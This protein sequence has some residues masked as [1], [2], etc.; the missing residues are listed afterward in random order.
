[1][2]ALQRSGA[3]NQA[4]ARALTAVRGGTLARG[5]GRNPTATK[6]RN[7]PR[8]TNRG[9]Q[10]AKTTPQKPAGGNP[11]NTKTEIP[12][13]ALPETPEVPVPLTEEQ[14][15]TSTAVREARDAFAAVSRYEER[16]SA[17]VDGIDGTAPAMAAASLKADDE[18]I[19]KRSIAVENAMHAA[20]HAAAS[21]DREGAVD[22]AR[23]GRDRA[24]LAETALTRMEQTVAGQPWAAA[25]EPGSFQ[26]I[27]A[28]KQK[29]VAATREATAAQ[30]AARDTGVIREDLLRSLVNGLKKEVVDGGWRARER[31]VKRLA[32]EA[33]ALKKLVETFVAVDTRLRAGGRDQRVMQELWAKH[34]PMTITLGDTK[35]DTATK[36]QAVD[37]FTAVL[38]ERDA[39]RAAAD[40]EAERLREE[41]ARP[42]AERAA[43]FRAEREEQNRLDAIGALTIDRKPIPIEYRS[44][45][46][47]REKTSVDLVITAHGAKAT[48]SPVETRTRGGLPVWDADH[49]DVKAH[50]PMRSRGDNYREF[51]LD[52]FHRVNKWG[53]RRLVYDTEYKRWYYSRTHYGDNGSPAFVLLLDSVPSTGAPSGS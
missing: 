33:K 31:A 47:A 16:A 25:I 2:L 5:R 22:A 50:L 17:I 39:T 37:A 44:S 8:S 46:P 23:K 51:Y 27:E 24:N 6:Q 4:I 26:E 53:S 48:V 28:I 40:S 42:A 1:M 3:G 35:H 41:R 7:Q 38:D 10:Q 11:A 45:L 13:I 19:F 30:S 29:H 20:V 12:Q 36:Q 18:L 49:A 14:T 52:P 9:G 43:E 32:D 21:G 34:T 15:V